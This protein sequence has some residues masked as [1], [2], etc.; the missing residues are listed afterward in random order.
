LVVKAFLDILDLG[1]REG[2]M[3]MVDQSLSVRKTEAGT[4][5]IVGVTP[6][7]LP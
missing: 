4:E 3:K 6:S 5:E 2:G 1:V 7:L